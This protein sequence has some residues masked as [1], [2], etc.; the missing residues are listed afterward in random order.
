MLALGL[1]VAV[2]SGRPTVRAVLLKDPH[3]A[4]ASA[5]LG[6]VALDQFFDLT[7]THTDWA[8]ICDQFARDVS[9]RTST[10]SPDVVVIRQA[11]FNPAARVTDGLR[12]R[13]VVEGAITSAALG[14]VSNTH[15]RRGKGC[16]DVYPGSKD[17]MDAA[18]RALMATRAEAAGA[19][20]SG[21]FGNRC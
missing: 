15:L 7:T 8:R 20:L 19:A 21:L 9:A 5:V 17:D 11:D 6:D 2:A 14:H 16:A 4:G 12:L 1:S 18:G 13:L 3:V 10:L